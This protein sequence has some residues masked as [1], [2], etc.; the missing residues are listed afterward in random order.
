MYLSSQ[1]RLNRRLRN[2]A[3]ENTM[4]HNHYT[5][6]KTPITEYIVCALTLL[7]CVGCY[8]AFVFALGL[9]GAR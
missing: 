5:T 2:R 8:M 9:G 1:S 6:Q 3:V 7:T 4:K